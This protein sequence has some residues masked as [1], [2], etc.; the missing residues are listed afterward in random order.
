VRVA[1]ADYPGFCRVIWTAHVREMSD[2]AVAER[3]LLMDI[4]FTVEQVIRAL[5]SPD[6]INLASF[7]NLTPHIHWH[8]IPRWH[9]DRH[10]PEPIW[11]RIHQTSPVLRPAVSDEALMGALSHQLS[12]GVA[13]D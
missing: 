8:V 4:V 7:G 11:G 9:D 10:F 5:F 12:A 1:D 6:K 13:S 3:Q 2:L